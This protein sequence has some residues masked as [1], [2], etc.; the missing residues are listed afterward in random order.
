MGPVAGGALWTLARA[1]ARATGTLRRSSGCEGH[2]GTLG[3]EQVPE[4]PVAP[5][6][7]TARIRLTAGPKQTLLASDAKEC[8]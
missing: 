2:G 8:A 5:P 6:H 4:T 7:P 3:R 1:G